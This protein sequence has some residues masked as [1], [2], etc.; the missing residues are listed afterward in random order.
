[1]KE[2]EIELSTD[3]MN[4]ILAQANKIPF[5]DILPVL[6]YEILRAET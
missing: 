5:L 3:Q 4:R 1:M 2:K 6:I